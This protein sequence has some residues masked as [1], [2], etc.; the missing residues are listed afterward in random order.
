MGT[1]LSKRYGVSASDTGGKQTAFDFS[2]VGTIKFWK[3]KEGVNKIDIIPYTVSS[4]AHPLVHNGILEKGDLDYT[5]ELWV[6]TY[7]G[8]QNTTVVCPKRNY[9]QPCPICEQAAKYHDEGK[10]EESKALWAKKKMYYNVQDAL[11]PG[12]GVQI[13]ETNFKY[14]EKPLRSLAKDTDDGT[15]FIDFADPKKGKTLKFTG[16]KEK[17]SGKDFIQFSNMKFLDRDE[18]IVALLKDAI[19]FDKYI[20]K[21]TYEELEAILFGGSID[22]DND[23]TPPPRPGKNPAKEDKERE[24]DLKDRDDEP[25]TKATKEIKNLCPNGHVFGADNDKYKDCAGCSEW[26]SCFKESLK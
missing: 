26:K 15:P 8:P 1:D 16:E 23:D 10:E 6:H 4:N 9:G 3:Q 24:S 21:Y 11:H 19:T 12:D 22:D 5:L 20:I 13:L 18:P 17:F 7:L 2:K 14:F 25:P